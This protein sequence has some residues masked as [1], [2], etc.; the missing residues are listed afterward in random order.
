[1]RGDLH[2]ELDR[3]AQ[4]VLYAPEQDM[5]VRFD[6]DGRARVGATHLGVGTRPIHVVH[7][8]SGR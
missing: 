6:T 8:A 3:L 2:N 7:S 1:M 4:D 5:W